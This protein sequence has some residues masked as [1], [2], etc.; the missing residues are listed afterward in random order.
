[1]VLTVHSTS[2]ACSVL[3]MLDRD[4]RAPCSMLAEPA[5]GVRVLDEKI[6][7]IAARLARKIDYLD[8][9]KLAREK[10]QLAS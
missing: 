7:R 4:Y 3:A 8:F 9:G 5:S 6:P 2:E 10:T 1:M